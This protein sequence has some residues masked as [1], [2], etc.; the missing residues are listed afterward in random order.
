MRRD[1]LRGRDREI[2]TSTNTL[3]EHDSR[4]A[5]ERNDCMKTSSEPFDEAQGERISS[6]HCKKRL[7]SW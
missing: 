7:R 3:H 5:I 6:R 2:H 4:E 1:R